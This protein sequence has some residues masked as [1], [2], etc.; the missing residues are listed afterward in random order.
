MIS[1]AELYDIRIAF[2]GKIDW[3]TVM[4][5]ILL[6]GYKGAAALEPMNWDYENLSM[7]QFLDIAYQRAK[8]IDGMRKI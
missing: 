7:R 8:K 2:D 6:T 1:E 5:R 4:R 3:Q